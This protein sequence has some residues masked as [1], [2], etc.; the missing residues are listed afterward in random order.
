MDSFTLQQMPSQLRAL[1][2]SGVE[3]LVRSGDQ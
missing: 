2:S 3:G 1:P